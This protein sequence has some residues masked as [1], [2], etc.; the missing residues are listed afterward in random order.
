MASPLEAL[1]AAVPNGTGGLFSCALLVVASLFS[2]CWLAAP[3]TNGTLGAAAAAWVGVIP[4]VTA[5][6][7]R[8]CSSVFV[9]LRL[10]A[11]WTSSQSRFSRSKRASDGTS[12]T[13]V[14]GA[15]CEVQKMRS[16]RRAC[17]RRLTRAKYCCISLKQGDSVCPDS[18]CCDA[19]SARRLRLE[20]G[21]IV[22]ILLDCCCCGVEEGVSIDNWVGAGNSMVLPPMTRR[23]L[24][25]GACFS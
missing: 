24:E 21:S 12:G 17:R 1:G 15:C 16:P 14:W 22:P 2:F 23:R 5:A 18:G 13:K 10:R 9:R 25:G 7:C 11:T 19:S 6:C 20:G 4:G 8:C 3:K